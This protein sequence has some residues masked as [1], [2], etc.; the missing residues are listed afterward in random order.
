MAIS[1]SGEYVLH[2]EAQAEIERLRKEVDYW[3]G[4]VS[5]ANHQRDAANARADTAHN[6]AIEAAAQAI[7]KGAWGLSVNGAA[8]LIRALKRTTQQPAAT[9]EA[10][11]KAI[12]FGAR[13]KKCATDGCE[14][15][16][17]DHI[18]MGGIGSDYCLDCA[19]KIIAKYKGERS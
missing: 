5:G 1:A 17:I 3:K 12:S 18:I 2:S 15:Q 7:S 4:H 14:G 11:F 9:P 8:D 19:D 6:A 13:Q 10:E 16:P